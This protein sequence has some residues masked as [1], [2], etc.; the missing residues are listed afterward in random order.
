MPLLLS[1]L[2]ISCGPL[3]VEEGA[4]IE[5]VVAVPA[6][7]DPAAQVWLAG[8]LEAVGSWR[9]DGL[10]LERQPD[11]RYRGTIRLPVGRPLEYK[12]TRGSWATVEKDARGGEIANRLLTVEGDAKVEIK[13]ASWGRQPAT[14]PRPSVSGD[15][16]YH[17]E[18]ASRHLKNQRT[19]AVYLPPDYDR[20]PD[21]RY[22]VL[23]LHDGQ[24]VF[25]AATSFLGVEW[26]AD[27]TAERLIRAGR[28]H[29]LIMVGVYNTP[30]RVDEYTFC[31]D[32]RRQAGGDARNY[33]RF[34]VE[35]VKPFIDRTYRTRPGREDTA[36]AGSSLGGLVSL[37]L[38]RW[39][40]ETF[41]MCGAL[42][43][44]LMWA[45]RRLLKECREDH[46][47]MKRT[48]FWLDMGTLETRQIATYN[49]A[50]ADARAWVG[51]FD[52]AGLIPGR[53]YYYAEVFE[54]EH[55][56]AHWAA[57]FDKVLLFFFGKR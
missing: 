28:I 45:D 5:F 3:P 24:N 26:Q 32:E 48:R 55:N 36:V 40:P 2:L 16:R 51:L 4:M 30:K 9:A 22:P 33:A 13:V 52:E 50:I 29:P 23:Y 12:I 37:C 21:A 7:T 41:S 56:E 8:S 14:Q 25:D 44:S 49:T 27:E 15:I 34:L 31:R 53:D 35:E 38:C 20:H 57:R 39:H 43:P 47:W 10:C 6:D 46:A 17:H 19:L 1:W 18:F 11:G 54:G 42:S